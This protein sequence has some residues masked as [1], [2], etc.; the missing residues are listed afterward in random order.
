MGS[1]AC[2]VKPFFVFGREALWAWGLPSRT[3]DGFPTQCGSFPTMHLLLPEEARGL[4]PPSPTPKCP[5]VSPRGVGSDNSGQ[6]MEARIAIAD[7]CLFR[8]VPLGM[9]RAS[10]VYYAFLGKGRRGRAE[11]CST[12][13]MRQSVQP[14][15]LK[16]KL[17][18]PKPFVA[19]R[20]HARLW[21]HATWPPRTL[22]HSATELGDQGLRGFRLKL[23]GFAAECNSFAVHAGSRHTESCNTWRFRESERKF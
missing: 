21:R 17:F 13:M 19:L 20:P 6:R 8:W 23:A 4:M 5:T 2:Q 9:R 1:L 10:C 12:P 11:R 7:S 22:G 3:W 16:L 18:D 15:A 14:Q